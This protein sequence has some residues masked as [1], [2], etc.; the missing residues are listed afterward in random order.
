VRWLVEHGVNLNAKDRPAFLLAVRY[1][2]EDVI[3]YVVD[4]G[5]KINGRDDLK[6]EA[7]TQALYGKKYQHLS[8]IH[9]LGHRVEKY[10][11]EAFRK[12]VS[13]RNYEALRF[14]L[15]HGADIN[16]NRPDMVYPFC[17]TP[18]C[19]AARYVDLE[20]CKF[21]VL[22]GA[23]ASMAEKDGMRPY[24]I[25]VEK[26]DHEMAAYFK[27]LEPAE[28][29][30]AQNKL[31]ELKAY[32]MPTEL[33]EFLQNGP[34]RLDFADNDYTG[35]MEFFSLVDTVPIKIGRQK[36]LRLSKEVENYG[37]FY[38]VWNPKSKRLA[39]YDMEHEE[40]C[41]IA[42]FAEFLQDAS[43]YMRKVIMGEFYS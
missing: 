15:E 23:D 24:S 31:R 4:H 28:L 19:V 16:Y 3:R 6:S 8:L 17:P 30:D 41:D 39:Y 18:L 11:G 20:M 34:L 36:L 22:H 42:P 7:F 14:F 33:L 2:D 5:A 32:K 43:G 27:S 13:D 35:Y 10:G 25:A 12:A 21:L 37:D 38:I 29:H 1:C 26:G 40:L 9:E